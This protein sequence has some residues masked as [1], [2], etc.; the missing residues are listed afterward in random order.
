MLAALLIM[1]LATTFALI[2]FGAVHSLK[3]SSARTRPGGARR[4]SRGE[5][6]RLLWEPSAGG[7]GLENDALEGVDPLSADGGKRRGHQ[8]PESPVT[9][10]RVCA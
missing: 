1:V 5:P 4:R 7:P 9:C 8:R 2:V 10:G 6:S 3:R